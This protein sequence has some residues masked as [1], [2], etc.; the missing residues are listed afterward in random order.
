MSVCE[1]IVSGESFPHW[2]PVQSLKNLVGIR[3]RIRTHKYNCS[4]GYYCSLY[5][6]L[7]SPLAHF[8]GS[9]D[10]LVRSISNHSF[11]RM[12]ACARG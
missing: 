8:I 5:A 2:W 4:H 7:Q 1:L 11:V 9:Y 12:S 10:H 6:H 3:I